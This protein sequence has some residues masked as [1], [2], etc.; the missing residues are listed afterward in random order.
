MRLSFDAMASQFDHQRGLP[1]EALTTWMNLI[2][3][4]AAGRSLQ[5]VEPGIGTGR[6]ALPLAMMGH[7]VSGT[8]ISQPMLTACEESASGI[9]LSDRL[10]LALSDATNLPFADQSFDLGVVAQL[11]YLVPDWTTVLDELARVV[12]PG[13]YVIHLTE[14]TNESDALAQWSA[15]WREMIEST[16]YRHTLITPTDDEVHTEFLRRWPDVRVRELASW[17]FG[18]TVSEAMN[19]YAERIRPLYAS[20][21]EHEFNQ[22]VENFLAWARNA[23]PDTDTRLEGTVTLTAMIASL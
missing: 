23:L 4:L 9:K 17:S 1:R 2:D 13:G 14:P 6:I 11:L 10:D 5:I 7:S 21:P 20:V 12:R 15:K 8:D 18:Q 3:E 22:A 16:G 19:G